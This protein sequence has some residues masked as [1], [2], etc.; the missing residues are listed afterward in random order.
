M[1]HSL[2]RPIAYYGLIAIDLHCFVVYQ[3][4][5]VDTL[6][7]CSYQQLVVDALILLMYWFLEVDVWP[8]DFVVDNHL[9]IAINALLL[10]FASDRVSWVS[11][12]IEVIVYSLYYGEHKVTMEIVAEFASQ[13]TL[14]GLSWRPRLSKWKLLLS[15]HTMRNDLRVKFPMAW[16]YRK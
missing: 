9:W 11:F 1:A 7:L 3:L 6:L 13:H 14:G 12:V 8:F 16:C 4:L 15:S 10:A 2:L 5:I